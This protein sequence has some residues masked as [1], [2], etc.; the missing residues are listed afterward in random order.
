MLKLPECALS[1]NNKYITK[2]NQ[3]IKK[4]FQSNKYVKSSI[5]NDKIMKFLFYRV[6]I[7]YVIQRGKLNAIKINN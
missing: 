7:L 2:L 1:T 4:K 5:K 3:F 6:E